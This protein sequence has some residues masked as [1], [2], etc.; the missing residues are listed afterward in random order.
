MDLRV[1]GKDLIQN[2]LTM[3]L[4]NH[5]CVWEKEPEM[6]PKGVF[7][8]GWLCVNNEKMSK[9]KGNFYT[10][11]DIMQKYSADAVR[12]ACADA[13]DTLEDANFQELLA[14]KALLFFPVL[15]DTVKN[16]VSGTDALLEADETSRF[17]DRWFSNEMNRLVSEARKHYET[18]YFREALRAAYFEFIGAFDKY[19]DICSACQCLPNKTLTL[20]YL[21]WQMIILSPICPHICE[22]AWEIMG[23]QGSVLD[24]RF[25]EPLAPSDTLIIRQGTYVF[26]DV[27]HDFIV[28]LDKLMAKMP[29]PPSC[30]VFIAKEFAPWKVSVLGVLGKHHAAGTLPLVSPDEMKKD[31]VAK[32]QWKTIMQEIMQDSSLKPFAKH[33]GPFAAF[34]RDEAATI[35]VEALNGTVP[36]DEE[37]LLKE[38]AGYLKDKLKMDVTVASSGAAVDAKQLDTFNLAQ[39]G[40]PSV[41][42]ALSSGDPGKPAPSKGGGGGGSAPG[43]KAKAKQAATAPQKATLVSAPKVSSTISDLAKLNDHLSTVSYFEGGSRPTSADAA[44]LAALPAA[45]DEGMYPHV[46]RWRRHISFFNAAQR[47]AW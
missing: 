22:K 43:G 16:L 26:D 31:D 36:F 39:P 1:S 33:L 44:Q 15:L 14:S 27:P 5:V 19:R 37:A 45:V 21:E 34:K 24:A 17:V 23:K 4:Y 8:N 10:L 3:S 11:N 18:M 25:P 28:L 13:G 41:F 20:R 38:H 35:G 29:R 42:F 7:C 32:A 12:L 6:W 47:A 40:K 46:A 30:T 2:H 9:S